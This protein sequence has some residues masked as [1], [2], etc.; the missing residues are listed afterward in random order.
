MRKLS[1]IG[2]QSAQSSYLNTPCLTME[3]ISNFAADK[4]SNLV[5]GKVS[6]LAAMFGL[7][8]LPSKQLYPIQPFSLHIS[9]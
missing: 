3:Q 5:T 2:I 8:V 6:D 7:F 9:T 4:A 1:G